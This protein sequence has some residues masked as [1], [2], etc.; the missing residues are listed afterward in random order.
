MSQ[1]I[2]PSK[3]E[4]IMPAPEWEPLHWTKPILPINRGDDIIDFAETALTASKGMKA[5]LPFKLTAWQEFAV[6]LILE[7]NAD[8]TLR[9]KRFC[10]GI[11]RK[12]GKSILGTVLALER[13]LY[14]SE[15][16]QIYAAARDRPQARI[17]FDEAR[18][19]VR[20]SQLLSEN[21]KVYRDAIENKKTGAIFR[22]ASSDAMSFQ[23]YGPELTVCDEMH[24]WQSGQAEEFWAA[25]N[26]ASG[27]LSE[28]LVVALSTA[29]RAKD[30][31]WGELY[32][33]GVRIINGEEKDDAFGLLWW[34]ASEEADPFDENEWYKSNPNLAEGLLSVKDL[35]DTLALDVSTGNLGQFKRYRLN[36]W[37]RSDGND[38]YVTPFHFMEA[39]RKGQKIEKGARVAIGFDGSVSDD[40]TAFVA[41]DIETGLLEILACW[42]RDYSNPDWTVPRHEVLEAQKRI[43]EEYQVE[44]MWCDPA[45]FQSDVENW[46]RTHR[47]VVERI[48]QSNARMVPMTEQL[49]LDLI[50]NFTTHGGDPRLRKHFL[51][52]VQDEN[53]K[54][55]KDKRGSKN[56]IDFAVCS[57]LANGARNKILGRGKK[58]TQAIILR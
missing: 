39:E 22:A 46:A 14:G 33:K 13:L 43:F 2:L 7:E 54:V 35:R 53:G 10:V 20:K 25:V 11:P 15:G 45:F 34:G 48:P 8:G 57:I 17:V 32:E 26:Q 31:L 18:K 49:K 16:T 55:K 40:S 24:A 27:D 47:R 19:Q 41:I 6:K 23:G 21:M 5:G 42:E 1:L 52:A 50:S 9:Y 12:N 29:G 30:T 38:M 36:Q 3:Q 4:L 58:S 37:V 51:N 44:K 28:S 56:K